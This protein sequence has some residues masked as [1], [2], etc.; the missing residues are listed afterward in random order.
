M[1]IKSKFWAI[2]AIIPTIVLIATMGA[3]TG[4]GQQQIALA[5]AVNLGLVGDAVAE[6]DLEEVFD[7][8]ESDDEE[9]LRDLLVLELPQILEDLPQLQNLEELTQ[10]PECP[11]GFQ[12]FHIIFEGRFVGWQC[13]AVDEE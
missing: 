4:V 10:V 7:E 11:V 9:D 1:L 12:A 3:I 5:Q 8:L 13:I 2:T 6:A